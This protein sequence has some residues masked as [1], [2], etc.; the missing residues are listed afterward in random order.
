MWVFQQ[1]LL[2]IPSTWDK[3]KV[4]D[5]TTCMQKKTQKIYRDSTVF[6]TNP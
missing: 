4:K 3:L 6:A 1:R 5:T 2:Q